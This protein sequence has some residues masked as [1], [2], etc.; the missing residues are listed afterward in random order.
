MSRADELKALQALSDDDINTEDLP[1]V[2][3]SKAEVGKF[4]R[5]VKQPVTIRIDADVLAWFKANNP[6][7]QT[8]V[9]KALRDYMNQHQGG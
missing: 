2:D 7:Y 1:E 8:A 3:F 5:P 4:Y 6:K 9:N